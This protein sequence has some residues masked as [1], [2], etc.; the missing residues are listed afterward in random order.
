MGN[1]LTDDETD[2]NEHG[3]QTVKTWHVTYVKLE[4]KLSNITGI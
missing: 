2:A 1:S 3:R 4:V